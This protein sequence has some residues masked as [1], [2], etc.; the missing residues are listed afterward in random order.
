MLTPVTDNTEI[1]FSEKQNK[2]ALFRDSKKISKKC[3]ICT[4][5]VEQRSLS[6]CG[7]DE[8]AVVLHR[9]RGGMSIR[10][11]DSVKAL[12]LALIGYF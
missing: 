8:P 1:S 5:I 3:F 9:A 10:V 11:I 2:L 7:S 12:L 6:I 4:A